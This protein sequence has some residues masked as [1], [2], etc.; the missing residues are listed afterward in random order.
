MSAIAGKAFFLLRCVRPGSGLGCRGRGR[1][2]LLLLR[3]FCLF[4]LK[5]AGDVADAADRLVIGLLLRL[6]GRDQIVIAVK[7]VL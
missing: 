7:R 1:E 4:M 2:V 3:S 5:Q 6:A